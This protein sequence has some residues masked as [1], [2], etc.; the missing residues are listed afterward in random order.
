M[1]LRA[2]WSIRDDA[3]ELIAHG[4]QHVDDA[5]GADPYDATLRIAHAI[6]FALIDHLAPHEDQS[7]LDPRQVLLF[8][9]LEL[10]A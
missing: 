10:H 4:I 1:T 8:P 2:T 3:G 7:P 6:E 9:S 5:P